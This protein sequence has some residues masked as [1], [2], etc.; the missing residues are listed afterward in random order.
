MEADDQMQELLE[1]QRALGYEVEEPQF[2]IEGQKLLDKEK[3]KRKKAATI[4]EIEEDAKE[5]EG[6]D[7]SE[8]S[9]GES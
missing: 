3:R 1:M 2:S 8:S 5:G 7:G 6:S 9:I 4:Y